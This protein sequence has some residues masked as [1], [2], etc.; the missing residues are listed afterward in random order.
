MMNL[1][2]KELLTV[3]GQMQYLRYKQCMT[4]Y[5]MS[6]V[7][8]VLGSWEYNRYLHGTTEI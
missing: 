7:V 2:R 3:T 4:L 1:T 8:S 5:C 6:D